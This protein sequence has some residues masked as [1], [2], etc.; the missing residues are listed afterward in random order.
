[1][2]SKFSEKIV[3][4]KFISSKTLDAPNDYIILRVRVGGSGVRADAIVR[5][6]VKAY[7]HPSDGTDLLQILTDDSLP[8]TIEEVHE[9]GF[10]PKEEGA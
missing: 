4:V 8:R 9:K 1:M 3:D 2:D 6:D 5:L 7:V 10:W